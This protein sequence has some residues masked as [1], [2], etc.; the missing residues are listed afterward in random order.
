MSP[1]LL[2]VTIQ[3]ASKLGFQIKKIRTQPHKV[4]MWIQ[5]NKDAC[6]LLGPHSSCVRE[7]AARTRRRVKNNKSVCFYSFSS[8]RYY[9]HHLNTMISSCKEEEIKMREHVKH[10]NFICV[11]SV[12][13]K[14]HTDPFQIEANSGLFV[15][16]RLLCTFIHYVQAL[17]VFSGRCNKI[18]RHVVDAESEDERNRRKKSTMFTLYL[19]YYQ[20]FCLQIQRSRVRFLALPDFLRSRGSGTGST[21][22]REDSWGATWMKK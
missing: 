19:K 21:Q 1:H 8:I 22:P 2:N 14:L 5:W 9:L 10:R 4:N 15:F 12:S 11:S 16:G 18:S 20:S 17:C 7:V 6:K 13:Y 3:I